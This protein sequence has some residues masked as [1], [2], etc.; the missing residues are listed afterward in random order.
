MNLDDRSRGAAFTLI[1][2]LVVMGIIGILAALL[3]PAINRA[4]QSSAEVVGLS[5]LKQLTT[6]T[7]SYAWENDGRL[8][9]AQRAWNAYFFND[10]GAYLNKS[11]GDG[12]LYDPNSYTPITKDPS[13][14]GKSG[15]NHFTMTHN[16]GNNYIGPVKVPV[17]IQSID[18]PAEMAVFFDGSQLP[19]GN[20]NVTGWAVDNSGLNWITRTNATKWF[21]AAW[22]EQAVN[23]GPNTDTSTTAGNIRWRNQNNTA[24]KFAFLDGHVAFFKPPDVKRK[25][26]MLP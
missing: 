20:V 13:V 2:L 12:T 6:A 22:I 23:P 1:E 18:H 3:P 8:P 19:D 26:F 7:I 16:V 15:V 10:I 5:N 25:F 24:A 9:Y 4:R 11:P 21:G 14:T 17:S